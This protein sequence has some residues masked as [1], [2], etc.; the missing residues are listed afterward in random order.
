MKYILTDVDG[1]LL[2]WFTPFKAFVKKMGRRTKG[3]APSDWHLEQWLPDLTWKQITNLILEFNASET[4]EVLPAFHDAE[5]YLPKLHWMDFKIVAI[6]SC[7]D[8][9]EVVKARK[10]NLLLAFGDI[11][12]EIHC[13]SLGQSKK[14]LLRSYPKSWWVEDRWDNATLGVECGHRAIIY[15]QPHNKKHSSPCVFRADS[16]MD[17]YKHICKPKK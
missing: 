2:D 12:H 8:S 13:L 5:A 3:A 7:D 15:T 9:K 11:F 6:T 16:W 17:I 1:V 14:K 4:F 10:R